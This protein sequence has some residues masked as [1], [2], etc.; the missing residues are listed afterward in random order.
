MFE[1]FSKEYIEFWENEYLQNIHNSLLLDK[2]RMIDGFAT[3]EEIREEWEEYLGKETSDF[4][5][6][7][8]RI[9]YW[10]FNQF[11]QPNSSPIGS[12]LFFKT[13]NAFIHIDIKTVTTDNI[14][15][16][17]G[18]I[19]VGD[20]QN[21]YDGY[22]EVRG[23]EPRKYTGNLPKI[24]TKNNGHKKMCLTYFICILYTN[25]GDIQFITL[26]SMPNGI[27]NET[28]GNKVLKAGKN[29]G[30]IRYNF[31][32]TPVFELLNN[33]PSRIKF[34]LVN[35]EMDNNIKSKAKKI[36]EF[37]QSKDAINS[38]IIS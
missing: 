30:K 6:G 19:F 9:F 28:Y 24:Y 32:K 16:I 8:E 36:L 18:S 29:P 33:K 21:S 7:S 31:S 1:E 25:N 17:N 22:I 15:D 12:D 10:L 2:E 38:K 13:Y 23:K 35:P 11:G 27:L 26:L 20:N 5:V 14:G 4:A 34:V 3:K 37:Y